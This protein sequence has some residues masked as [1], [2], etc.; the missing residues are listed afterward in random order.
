VLIELNVPEVEG[1]VRRVYSLSSRP[2]EKAIRIT[3][4]REPGL[5]IASPF[6]HEWINV[7]DEVDMRYPKGTFVLNEESERPVVLL[8]AGVGLTPMI[9]MM[10]HLVA[11]NSNRRIWFVHAATS[12]REHAMADLVRQIARDKDNVRIHI[13]YGNPREEDLIGR[14]FDTKGS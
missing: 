4:K 6:L 12:G 14:D 9:S 13:A 5:A 8:S 7:G 1:R 3:V 2:G 11:T 10:E